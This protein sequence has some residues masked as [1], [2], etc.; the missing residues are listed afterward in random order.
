MSSPHVIYLLSDAHRGQAMSHMGDVNVA[1]PAM[2]R[3]AAEGASFRRAYANC[4]ICTPSRGSMFSGRHAHAGPVEFFFDVYKPAFPSTATLLREQGYHTAYFGKWHC[5]TVRNQ[6]P[7]SV[8]EANAAP[9]GRRFGGVPNRTPERHRAGFQD[10]FGFENLNQHFDSYYYHNQEV[11][12][13]RVDGYE[14]DAYTDLVLDYLGHYDRESPLFLVLSVTPPHFPLVVPEKWKRHDPASLQVPPNFSETEHHRE[15]LANYYAMIE[16]LDW[17]LGRI[18]DALQRLPRFRDNT[19]SLYFSDHGDFMGS[20]GRQSRKEHP[21]EESVRIPAIWHWPGRIPCQNVT[22]G[23]FSI[24]DLLPTTMGLLGLNVPPWVQGTDFSPALRG[25]AFAGPK[26]VLLEM[27]GSPRWTLDFP[28]W[29]GFTDGRWKYA[30]YDTGEQVLY[31]LE[32][33]PYEQNNLAATQPETCETMKQRLLGLLRETGEPS[34]H[35][36]M[37]YG[38][39]FPEIEVDLG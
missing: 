13:I 14:T 2:D 6:I 32:A 38:V 34:F 21:Q 19:L 31:D 27:S 22:E 16:N 15:C 30:Y 12:P 24:V 39:P 7:S 4:P 3:M 28:D 20:H 11:D 18:M 37:E 9:A 36:L 33:D 29:R 26:E 25:E 17:N 35:V 10:W 5:G 1:T 8:R 23:L